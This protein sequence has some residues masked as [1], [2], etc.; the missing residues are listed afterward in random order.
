VKRVVTECKANGMVADMT[1][2]QLYETRKEHHVVPDINAYDG[3]NII[4]DFSFTDSKKSQDGTT[5]G[6]KDFSSFKSLSIVARESSKTRKFKAL[7]E[8]RKSDFY[9]FVVERTTMAL[10]PQ[11]EAF[12]AR[13]SKSGSAERSLIVRTSI[14]I[15]AVKAIAKMLK[16]KL[17][18]DQKGIL[19]RTT[20]LFVKI[21]KIAFGC[22]CGRR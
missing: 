14:V 5:N 16:V 8:K 1:T 18:R 2:A 20:K 22:C 12:C 21:L 9:A 19:K 3:K 10:G 6:D 4:V 13:V 11:A 7:A 15:A 17:H